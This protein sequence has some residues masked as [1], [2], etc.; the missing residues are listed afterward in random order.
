MGGQPAHD[1]AEQDGNE[2]GAFNERVAGRELRAIEVVG[3]DA[4]LDRA[5][6]R[7]ADAETEQCQ[8]QNGH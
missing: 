4:V 2:G 7:P 8:E 5:E 1:G 6:Q 3:Q